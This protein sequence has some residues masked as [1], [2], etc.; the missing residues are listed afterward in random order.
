MTEYRIANRVLSIAEETPLLQ[1]F[2]LDPNQPLQ[3]TVEI[4]SGP[5]TAQSTTRA[6]GFVAGRDREVTCLSGPDSILVVVEDLA[7]FS[8]ARDG[9]SI[10]LAKGTG[11]DGEID[12]AIL[13]PPLL[14]AL[15]LQSVAVLH[16]GS[17]AT[18]NGVVAF[19]GPSGAGKSTLAA[20]LDQLIGEWSRC[21]DDLLPLDRGTDGIDALPHFPQLKL[22]TNEQWCPPRPDRI[23]LRALFLLSGESSPGTGI[24]STA[25]STTD[26]TVAILEHSAAWTFFPPELTQQHLAFCA[27][28]AQTVPVHRLSYPR[29]L[30]ALQEVAAAIFDDIA[31]DG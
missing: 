18:K 16:A 6:T 7:E 13:G 28:I 5:I 17:V 24:T 26:A 2:L 8:V 30:D 19:L 20:F 4:P 22:S 11:S 29:R 12:Q 9:S 3:R 10:E 25:L 27:R 23:P 1:L 31:R 14:L 21:T 15:A